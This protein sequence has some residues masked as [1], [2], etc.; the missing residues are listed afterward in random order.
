MRALLAAMLLGASVQAVA[1][2]NAP[3]NSSGSDVAVVSQLAGDVTYSS[4]AP[5][6]SSSRSSGKITPYMR[7]REGDRVNV[8]AG[9]Q[10]R[11]V[12]FGTG[13][14]ERWVGPGSFRA[15]KGSAQPLSGTPAE[16]VV[17]PAS[18]PMRIARVP[19]LLQN[20]K[21]GG[22]QVRS[23]PTTSGASGPQRDAAVREARAAY[24]QMR[25]VSPASDI[26]PELFLYAALSE[27]SLY[28]D[29]RPVVQEMLRK[30]PENDDAKSL[31]AW[32]KTRTGK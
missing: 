17:L 25:N 27:H 5:F 3:A 30:Q 20:A 13:R 7:V 6:S 14:Q 28:D 12:F 26:T 21:L 19:E 24:E 11:L 29:M 10:L 15:A 31:A 4:A 23:P 16:V 9:A 1:Q 2:L 8:P 18:A 32:L 22:I